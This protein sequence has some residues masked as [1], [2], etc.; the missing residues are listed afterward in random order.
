[1]PSKVVV[2]SESKIL[3]ILLT[4]SRCSIKF[5]EEE[6]AI[7]VDPPAD[8]Y[9][10]PIDLSLKDSEG[11]ELSAVSFPTGCTSGQQRIRTDGFF[12][13]VFDA[14]EPSALIPDLV[15]NIFSTDLPGKFDKFNLSVNVNLVN[16]IPES[17]ELKSSLVNIYS[18]SLKVGDSTIPVT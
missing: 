1:M 13:L 12:S 15:A 6:S 5:S 8:C 4:N 9:V 11:K 18:G 17:F 7:F 14:D 3:S 2:S 10:L 16:A